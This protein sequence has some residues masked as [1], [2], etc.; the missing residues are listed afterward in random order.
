MTKL[1]SKTTYQSLRFTLRQ[2]WTIKN[3]NVFRVP[4]K[5]MQ[6]TDWAILWENSRAL[7][8]MGAVS[9]STSIIAL[10]HS[11]IALNLMKIIATGNG[12][13][14]AAIGPRELDKCSVITVDEMDYPES[15]EEGSGY[16]IR[17]N[18][19]NKTIRILSFEF[20]QSAVEVLNRRI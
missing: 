16:V 7:N 17:K 9:N 11:G 14:A 18:Q 20:A 19:K 10:K 1:L 15:V 5:F 2:N 13:I 6:H 3:S 8:R 12:R 4:G